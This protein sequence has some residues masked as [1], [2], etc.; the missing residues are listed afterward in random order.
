MKILTESKG[1]ADALKTWIGIL[2]ILFAGAYSLLEYI[3]HKQ[4]VKI[5]RSLE[6]VS[7]F[8]GGITAEA[9]LS[10]NQL[11]TDQSQAL[12]KILSNNHLGKK[13]L[14]QSYNDFILRITKSPQIQRNLEVVFSFF[15]EVVICVEKELCDKEVIQSF[16]SNEARALFNSYYPYVCSLRKQWNNKTVYLKLESFYLNKSDDICS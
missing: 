15:E 2:A 16:F 14:N 3:E 5:E 8:R 12:S 1:L 4:T 6:Y 11:L 9:R 7:N 10:L 13:Q